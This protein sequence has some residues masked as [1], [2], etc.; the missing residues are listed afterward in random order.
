MQKPS[1]QASGL[2]R[3]QAQP[4]DS[5]AARPAPVRTLTPSATTY[6]E[7]RPDLCII[8][9]GSGG[10]SVAAAAAQL[11][12]SVVLIEKHKMGGDCL[13][14]GCV[15]SKALLAAAARAHAMRTADPFGI[16]AVR[17]AIDHRAVYEHVR[18]VIA[19]IAP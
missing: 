11:G 8:G 9:A 5:A 14:Y 18:G 12:V 4:P 13:Y 10:L 16:S 7:L 17:P 1:E 6:S 19:A 3:A 2:Q 15:P